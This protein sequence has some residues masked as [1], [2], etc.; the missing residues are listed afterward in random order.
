[1]RPTIPLLSLA[2]AI[3]VCTLAGPFGTGAVF[4]AGP[5]FLFWLA[6]LGLNTALWQGA[7]WLGH[8]LLGSGRRGFA[9]TT[10]A[11]APLLNLPLSWEIGAVSALLG[12]PIDVPW[13]PVYL[14]AL[15][16]SLLLALLVHA[17]QGR[18]AAVPE[19]AQPPAPPPQPAQQAAPAA[20]VPVPP[21]GLLARA[22][23]D[24]PG[25]LLAVEAE[26]HYLRLHL[27]DGRSPLVHY[28]LKDA[29]VELAGIDGQQVHRGFWVAAAAVA[30]AARENRKW[31]LVLRDGRR[32]PVSESFAPAA[33]ARGWL[34]PTPAS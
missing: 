9:L 32:V 17:A 14:T 19:P 11:A 16:F 24:D 3:A 18:A 5:R 26:D 31:L 8:R 34:G 22:G 33:R 2:A 10:A 29:L 25:L 7:M 15:L 1:M 30:G 4:T 13:L 28:R 12:R 6:L 20:A 21:T 23:L 27:S